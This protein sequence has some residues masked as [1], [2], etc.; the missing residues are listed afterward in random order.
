MALSGVD[1]ENA[2]VSLYAKTRG[3]DKVVTM[4]STM[5]YIDFFKST[6]LESIVSPKSSMAS[7]ILRYVRSMANTRDSDIESLHKIMEGRVEALEFSVKD[8]IEGITGIPLKQLSARKGVLIACIVR[9]EKV[10]IP[11]GD[12]K[13]RVGDTVIVIATSGQMNNIKDIV[14]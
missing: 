3:A 10:I 9:S 2:I 1:E 14:K 8:D 6:G 11:S 4:I 12:D 5:S 7:V 13:I